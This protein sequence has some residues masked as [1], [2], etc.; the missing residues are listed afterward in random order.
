MWPCDLEENRFRAAEL[1]A[2][3]N[4]FADLDAVALLLDV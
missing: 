1:Y 3:A 4:T 2:L